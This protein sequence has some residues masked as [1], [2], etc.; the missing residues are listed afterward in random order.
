MSIQLVSLLVS[1]AFFSVTVLAVDLSDC[2]YFN[3]TTF[4]TNADA[5]KNCDDN[6][7]KLLGEYV[8]EKEYITTLRPC[9]TRSVVWV[10]AVYVNN[11]LLW[12]T[13]GLP[14]DVTA[15]SNVIWSSFHVKNCVSLALGS[16]LVSHECNSLLNAVCVP[17]YPRQSL[18]RLN[19]TIVDDPII[20]NNTN[21]SVTLLQTASSTVTHLSTSGSDTYTIAHPNSATNSNSMLW[22]CL[23]VSVCLSLSVF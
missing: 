22:R 7:F 18:T 1:V 9:L 16:V 4:Y 11:S 2:S 21:D 23:V 15:F 5:I 20:N 14:V 6:G 10:D 19:T 12:R 13:N 8:E 17:A 3:S